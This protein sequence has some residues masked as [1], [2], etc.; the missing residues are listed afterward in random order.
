M[1]DSKLGLALGYLYSFN[2]HIFALFFNGMALL[3]PGSFL[4]CDADAGLLWKYDLG[5]NQATPW[6]QQEFLTRVDPNNPMPAANGIKVHED[7]VFVSNTAR[8]TLLTIPLIA[9]QPGEPAIYILTTSTLM[10][11]P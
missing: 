6:L 11:L 9:G 2:V 4:I 8:N 1:D 5:S 7:S 3:A 10:I